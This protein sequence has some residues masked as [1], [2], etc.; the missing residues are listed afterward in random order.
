MLDGATAV[1]ANSENSIV[2]SCCRTGAQ[3]CFGRPKI[4]EVAAANG[5]FV[6]KITD[7]G[8]VQQ[9]ADRGGI[10]GTAPQ[11]CE[12]EVLFEGFLARNVHCQ[13]QQHFAAEVRLGSSGREF[14]VAF[15]RERGGAALCILA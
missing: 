8:R 3:R 1:V 5:C 7:V 14:C 13:R 4:I 6:Q 9:P 15:H 11:R 12:R 10:S 2:F